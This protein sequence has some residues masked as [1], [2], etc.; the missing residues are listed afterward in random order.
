M[1]WLPLLGLVCAMAACGD[2]GDAAGNGEPIGAD[3]T[4]APDGES[5]ALFVTIE[6]PVADQVLAS[7]VPVIFK[8]RIAASDGIALP[9]QVTWGSDVDVELWTGETLDDELTYQTSSLSPGP[10][11]VT[12]LATDSGGRSGQA[13]VA[14]LVDR[15]PTADTVVVIEPSQPTSADPLTAVLIEEATDPD[16]QEVTYSFSWFS[17]GLPVPNAGPLVPHTLT[18]RGQTWRVLATPFDGLTKG[19]AGEAE[20]VIGNGVPSLESAQ[21]LPSIGGTTATFT[22]SGEGWSDADGDE[23]AYTLA[24]WLNG[25]PLEEVQESSIGGEHF[26]RG[27]ELF[28]VLTPY[29]AY[30]EGLPVTSE[31]V[32]IIDTPPTVSAALID[33]TEGDK[34]TTF[35]CAYEGL[36]DVDEGDEP[37]VHIVWVVNGEALPGTTSVT[38]S[39][40]GLS[41]GDSVRCRIEPVSGDVTGSP[42][43]SVEVTLGNA[44][45]VAGAVVME[46]IPPTELTGVTC[47]AGAADD[48]DGDNVAYSYAWTVNDEPVEGVDGDFLSGEHYDKG[49]VIRCDAIPFDGVNEGEAASAKFSATAV[50]TPPTLQGATVTPGEGGKT[51]AFTCE[52]QGWSDVD[53]ADEATYQWAWKLDGVEVAGGIFQELTPAGL[54]AGFLTCVI[55]PGDGESW[56]EP[57]ESGPALVVNNAPSVTSVALGPEPATELTELVCEPSGWSDADGD[58]ESYLVSWTVDGVEVP[59]QSG[60]TLTGEHFDKTDIVICFA[61]PFDGTDQGQGKASNPVQIQNTEPSLSEAQIS[62]LAGG[63]LTPFTCAPGDLS[64]P[65]S[66]DEVLL[67]VAWFVGDQVVPGATELVWTP[68]DAAAALDQIRCELTPFDG[69]AFG[70]PISSG[71][72]LITNSA[73]IVASVQIAPETPTE[74]DS[75][76]CEA[77]DVF[78]PDGDEVTLSYIWV[79]NQ[80]PLVGEVDETLDSA[81]TSPGDVVRCQV[82]PS[83]LNQGEG[84]WSPDTLVVEASTELA[85]P[86]VSVIPLTPTAGEALTCEV[87]YPGG[88]GGLSVEVVWKQNGEVVQGQD[89]ATLPAGLVEACD[90]WVCEARVS[91]GESFGPWADAAAFAQA[92]GGGEGGVTW[93]GH[94][95]YDPPAVTSYQTHDQ[96]LAMEVA[97]TRVQLDPGDLPLSVTH[98]RA[99]GAQGQGYSVRLYVDVG[100][101]PGAELS[102]AS[103]TGKGPGVLSEVALPAPVN[104]DST[105]VWV[106]IQGNAD[107]WSV[108]GDGDGEST[109]NQA[110]TCIGIPGFGCLSDPAWGSLSAL[111]GQFAE[112]DDLIL[113]LGVSEQGAGGCP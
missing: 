83:D 104:V 37:S 61:V 41:E 80:S 9:A 33:P 63:K 58:P 15:P 2:A 16:G 24:W 87:G 5:A 90:V 54:G 56:G 18:A 12:L 110:Y 4:G 7:G 98:V 14:I 29:D 64:D 109:T 85:A 78:D 3:V 6:T 107:L 67:S 102:S 106:G 34:T 10:H 113:D 48:P 72:A 11:V 105:S 52:P 74:D 42:M 86:E 62:P 1:K 21:I 19:L 94:H 100:G 99:L 91:D 35:S 65:D 77:Q 97:A 44:P 28:C 81:F 27:D 111:G 8:A 112:I 13:S 89:T 101:A 88:L 84:V 40:E 68:G 82:T 36:E 93:F 75:L 57:V 70:D 108:Y 39:A 38:F 95:S 66:S 73:P 50:N 55:T 51:D 103:F 47:V 43:D 17:D 59:E 49:D 92:L 79:L 96:W 26:S 76:T 46:P 22:C 30:D 53:P 71:T 31:V 32:T 60:A 20:V 45:P 23:E 69:A 25:A